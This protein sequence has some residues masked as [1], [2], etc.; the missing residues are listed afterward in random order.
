MRAGI[1]LSLALSAAASVSAQ[2]PAARADSTRINH[3]A[4]SAQMRFESQRRFLAP[5]TNVGSSGAC[6]M[7]GRFCRHASGVSFAEIPDEP[8]A[9][10]RAREDLLKVLAAAAATIPGDG[11]V[12]GQRVRY[13]IESGDDSTAAEAASGC[14]A[15]DWWC[16]ALVGLAA[17]SSSHFVAAEQAFARSV[18]EMPKAVRC[19]WTDLSDLLDGDALGAYRKLPC[20]AR[21]AANRRIWW[22]ADPLFSTPGNERRTEHFARHVWAEIDRGGT[23]GFGLSW[24]ADMKEMIIRFGWAE[25]WTQQPPTGLADGSTSYVAHEREPDFH[26]ISSAPLNAPISAIGDSSW[27]LTQENPREGYS[28]RY[29]TVFLSLKPQLARFRRGDSTLIVAAFDVTADTTWRYGWVR[30]ALIVAQSDTT[31]FLLALFDSTRRRSALWI[32]APAR[33]SLVGLEMLSLDGK[34]AG[35]WRGAIAPLAVG[36]A[37]R[38]ISDLLFFDA[39]D[40]LANGIEAAISGAFGANEVSRD[41][42]IGVYWE[43]YGDTSADSSRAISLTLTPIAPGIVTRLIRALGVGK[44]LT[45]VDVRWSESAT[46]SAVSARSVAL[47]LSAVT[48]G[49][50]ELRVTVGEGGATRSSSRI[51]VIKQNGSQ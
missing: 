11:W 5:R 51:V 23:N 1:S 6:Q 16:D 13:L 21:D 24:A 44:K 12:A 7:I 31:R 40:S 35:R 47:D 49:R 29:A 14:K 46:G 28:P 36:T 48:P 32:T 17:H 39:R 3:S 15:E 4:K 25:K 30:P 9:T 38:G 22:L 42:K 45:P 43:T 27:E 18:R 37:R 20:D 41:R 10:T 34:I 8:R 50:Y 2:S 33:E 19:E 26:F